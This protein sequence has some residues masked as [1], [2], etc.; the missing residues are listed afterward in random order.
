M[1]ERRVGEV[2]GEGGGMV[3]EEGAEGGVVVRGGGDGDI[4]AE[5]SLGLRRTNSTFLRVG[6][7][8]AACCRADR[9]LAHVP[10][11]WTGTRNIF[12]KKDSK[13]LFLAQA[14]LVQPFWISAAASVPSLSIKVFALLGG[15][16][17]ILQW[18]AGW[19]RNTA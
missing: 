9:G 6:T 15:C 11:R 12:E 1:V 19:H 7:N 13:N 2:G 8:N 10:A 4:M 3:M 18:M 16:I 5:L 14:P 17:Q